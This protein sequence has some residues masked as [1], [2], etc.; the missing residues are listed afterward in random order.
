MAAQRLLVP[1]VRSSTWLKLM[2]GL[3]AIGG[4]GL[5]LGAGLSFHAAKTTANPR[6]PENSTAL[7]TTGLFARTRNPMYLGMVAV[8]TSYAMWRG[9]LLGLVP[10]VALACWLDQFQI[11]AE[12]DALAQKYGQAYWQYQRAVPR[13][14]PSTERGKTHAR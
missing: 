4:A 10:S 9:S 2:A 6:R 5:A 7:V 8:S 14:I 13:W 11:P 12:E 3:L 1:E